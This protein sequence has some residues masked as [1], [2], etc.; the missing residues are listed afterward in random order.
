MDNLPTKQQLI[1]F[2]AEVA[3]RFN[4]GEIRAPIHLSGGNEDEL[5]YIF[6]KMVKPRDWVFSTWRS[7]YHC[8]LKGVPP[9]DLMRDI[10]AGKSI[11]LC[12]PEYNVLSSA[13]VGGCAPIALGVAAAIKRMQTI[14]LPTVQAPVGVDMKGN[15]RFS[16]GAHVYVFIGDMAAETGLVH[17]CAKY[18]MF[19]RL[20]ITWV[21][22]DNGVS[23]C[24]DTAESWGMDFQP[25]HFYR[26]RYKLP[27][28]HSGAGER[29]QF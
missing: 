2:E 4:A 29:V 23:V 8:L 7:H 25:Q 13:I 16:P 21:V 24:T 18:A 22:E 10:L 20:P 15:L 14:P 11:T 17:E 3:R 1:D 6:D 28:H 12:Y 9:E 19:N 26:Y 27:H 5:I